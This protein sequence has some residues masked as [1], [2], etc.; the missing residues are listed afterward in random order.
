MRLLSLR[1]RWLAVLVG[2]TLLRAAVFVP[3]LEAQ[4]PLNGMTPA[5]AREL[6]QNNPDLQQQLRQRIEQSAALQ[7]GDRIR[8]G[9][10]TLEV[11]I[12]AAAPPPRVPPQGAAPPTR[13]H[14]PPATP[15]AAPSQRGATIA[16]AGLPP[17]MKG[18][19][20]PS[21]GLLVV[22]LIVGYEWLLS[23]LTKLFRGGFPQGLGADLT[24]KSKDSAEW[25]RDFL[26]SVLIPQA[27]TFGYLIE[28]TELIVGVML[29]VTALLWIFR[30]ERMTSKTRD[31][32][33]LGIVGASLVAISMNIGFYLAT[34]DPLP[35]FLAKSPFDEGVG[36]DVLLPM[37]ELVLA[38]VSF[39]TWRSLRRARASRSA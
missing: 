19:I 18:R 24:E 13:V 30:W 33:L 11:D 3:R 37:L 10:T 27:K 9:Q 28:F 26:E 36:L 39:W 20:F 22:Q 38:G 5:Q 7:T 17:T 31:A 29:I 35:F 16:L 8:L 25:Y 12:P 21:I 1:A 32:V 15:R 6:L 2:L 14:S 34:G 23:A 4:D